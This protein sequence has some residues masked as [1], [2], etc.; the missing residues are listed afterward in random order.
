MKMRK[1]KDEL[2]ET[3]EILLLATRMKELGRKSNLFIDE[4]MNVLQI[5]RMEGYQ[6]IIAESDDLMQEYDHFCKM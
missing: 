3:A 5:N 4:A 2:Y 6:K 1:K